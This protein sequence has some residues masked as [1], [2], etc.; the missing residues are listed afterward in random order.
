MRRYSPR[1][2]VVLALIGLAV[3][4]YFSPGIFSQPGRLESSLY[5]MLVKLLVLAVSITVHEF[6]HAAVAYSLGDP[7][8]KAEGRVS[9]NPLRHLDVFGTFMILFGPIGWGKPVR[10]NPGN[11]SKTNIR[12]AMIAVSLA[13]IFMNLLLA[14]VLASILRNGS[15]IASSEA[16]Q[17]LAQMILLNIGL[18]TFNILPIPPLD[19]YNF[20]LGVL[21]PSLARVLWPLNQ[22]GFLILI[23]LIMLP[24]I[25]GPDVIG[26]LI[27]P[28]Y[29]V[30]SRLVTG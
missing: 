1:D 8:P 7:T 28:V 16:R 21:P 10:W 24:Q 14:F 15:L 11:V 2:W 25:G 30:F 9:L 20:W 27:T 3:L 5:A 26:A 6:G 23:G 17:I 4:Y 18:A 19:G 12:I 13:G 29:R 22:Y